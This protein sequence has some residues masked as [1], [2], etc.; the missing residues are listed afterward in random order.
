MNQHLGTTIRQAR[1]SRQLLLRKA[2]AALDI[3]AGLLS[4]IERNERR[5]TRNQVLRFADLYQ[6]DA[7]ALLVDWLSDRLLKELK[8]EKL[9]RQ[10]IKAVETKITS[11]L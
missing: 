7:D 6:L 10:V 2:A 11:Q 9:A 5:A 1:E 8:G 3:D 4:K